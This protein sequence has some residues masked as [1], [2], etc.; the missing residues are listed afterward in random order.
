MVMVA[1]HYEYIKTYGLVHLKMVNFPLVVQQLG[2][3][4]FTAKSP[5]SI[6]GHRAKIPQA[7]INT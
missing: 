7:K 2:L 3:H 6:S 1:H 5:G 4:I